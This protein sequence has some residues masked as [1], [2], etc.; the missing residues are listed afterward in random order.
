MLDVQM[1]HCDYIC[2]AGVICLVQSLMPITKIQDCLKALLN[3][4]QSKITSLSSGAC[5]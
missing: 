5:A 3:E 4:T 1:Q 2:A